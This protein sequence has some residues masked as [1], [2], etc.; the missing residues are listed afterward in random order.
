MP[1]MPTLE[2]GRD[3]SQIKHDSV[4]LAVYAPFG[5]D[6][7]LSIYPSGSATPVLHQPLV[8]ALQRVATE[9]V[10][11]SC[12]I[13]LFEDDS[14]LV[15]IPA[16][17]AA[18]IS[19]TS[20]WKQD[21]STPQA[22]AGFLRRT[23]ARFDCST[24]VLALEGHGGGFLPEIDF[25]RITPESITHWKQGG[26]EGNVRWVKSRELTR[27]EQDDG[28][29]PLGMSSPELGMSSPEL[30]ASRLPLSTWAIGEA[31]RLAAKAGVPGPAVIHFNNC[32]NASIELLHTVAPYADFATGYA[33]Y[34]FFTA[35]EAYPRV[36]RRLGL[37]NTASREKLAR[38]FAEENQKT[39]N[40]LPLSPGEAG[41]PT[42][43]ATVDLS[44][45][46]GKVAAAI[47]KLA[48]ALTQALQGAG[49]NRPTVLGQ[50]QNAVGLAQHYDTL[51]GR[52]LD[53][54]DEFMD[55]GSFAVQLQKQPLPGNVGLAATALQMLLGGLHVYGDKGPAAVQETPA[56]LYDFSDPRLALNIFFPD[57]M[58]TGQWDWR[59]PY[60][61]SGKVDA[62]KPPPQ[63]RVIDF[64]TDTAG[65]RPRWVEFIVEY[66]ATIKFI[67][68]VPAPAFFFPLFNPR[69]S[70]GPNGPA[71]PAGPRTPG[72][73]GPTPG[74]PKPTS[75]APRRKP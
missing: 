48:V 65:H 51:P 31:L 64:L 38:W 36:F 19:I 33:N 5:T 14:Y 39:L 63:R 10:N 21:M 24:L 70:N 23:H 37:A 35:G 46:R 3:K 52:V 66:H 6:E 60:Y 16:F 53:K 9:G 11:V 69:G 22:L 75:R 8:N 18:A 40:G 54:F 26:L 17:Q 30:P 67:G 20:V 47:D 61:L 13:D 72:N 68:F 74:T 43:G 57:P 2:T 28:P 45:L 58:L 4:V 42:V 49:A 29:P 56:P 71:G 41:Y 27:F 73:Q 15:E 44:T 1:K 34:D 7:R 62:T 50:I 32:F 59:S 55:L 25:A 12:L